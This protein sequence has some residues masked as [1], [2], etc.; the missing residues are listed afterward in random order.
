MIEPYLYTFLVLL[1]RGISQMSAKGLTKRVIN[2][3]KSHESSH[4]MFS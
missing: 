1:T 3:K 4:V 2:F